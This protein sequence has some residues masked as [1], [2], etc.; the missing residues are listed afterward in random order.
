MNAN[1]AIID[2]LPSQPFE[3]CIVVS[4]V[5]TSVRIVA[6]RGPLFH[7]FPGH[8]PSLDHDRF[9]G[10]NCPAICKGPCLK[11][12][13][14]I[15]RAKRPHFRRNCGGN[16]RRAKNIVNQSMRE[17]MRRRMLRRNLH[18]IH[19]RCGKRRR[20]SLLHSQA[21]GS[22]ALCVYCFLS[23]KIFRDYLSRAVNRQPG[24]HPK[25]P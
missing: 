17:R 13:S 22:G 9:S 20:W 23:E 6:H 10:K 3:S 18:W 15:H 14:N 5:H 19:H 1:H 16:R 11:R 25:D 24:I 4:P 21:L 8:L 7:H 2:A 12:P